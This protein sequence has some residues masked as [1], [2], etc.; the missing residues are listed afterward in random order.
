MLL[1]TAQLFAINLGF[2]LTD[3]G[4]RPRLDWHVQQG[5]SHSL[6]WQE[7]EGVVSLKSLIHIIIQQ[8]SEGSMC[9]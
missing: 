9:F 7:A 3:L 5:L 1:A 8:R 6:R 4:Q 2:L